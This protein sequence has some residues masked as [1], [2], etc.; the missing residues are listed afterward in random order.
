MR[1]IW[2]G[3]ISFG[4]VNI[5]IGLALATQRND[6][7]FRTLHRECGT[8]IKQKLWCPLH[9]REVEADELVKGWEFAKGQYVLVEEGDLEAVAL[10]RSQSIEILRF[11]KLEEV[12]PVFF[13]RTYYL[14]PAGADAQRRPYVLLLRAMQESGMAA[15]GKFV[16][17]GKENLCLIRA[18]G[19][20]LALELLFFGEDVRSKAEIEEAVAATDVKEPELALATQVIASLAGEWDPEAPEFQNDYRGQLKR[21]LE[22]KLAG[23]EIAM[24]E[25]VAETPVV[26]LMEALRR[27]VAD[28]QGRRAAAGSADGSK[29]TKAAAKSGS[30]GRKTPARKSA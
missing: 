26:D 25:P 20:A 9:D 16:L 13:D 19:E 12:D 15:V 22:A 24:P 8:P 21:M 27:S 2:N 14:A 1:T 5:P 6:I 23:E 30:R 3:S 17:W 18:Q 10:Q 4:L 28:A 7:S 29:N 11:V